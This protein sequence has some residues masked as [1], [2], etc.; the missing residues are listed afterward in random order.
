MAKFQLSGKMPK[1]HLYL[2]YDP[3][4]ISNY[5]PILHHNTIGKAMGTIFIR[6]FNLYLGNSV[7][8]TFQ[9]GFVPKD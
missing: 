1:P 7:I 5:Q 6:S 2:R 8:T 3:L 9:S 4:E